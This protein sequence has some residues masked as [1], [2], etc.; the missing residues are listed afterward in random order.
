MVKGSR[1]PLDAPWIVVFYRDARAGRAVLRAV[2]SEH[3]PVVVH[4]LDAVLSGD[5]LYPRH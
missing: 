5:C 4:H 1:V 2:T 3:Y